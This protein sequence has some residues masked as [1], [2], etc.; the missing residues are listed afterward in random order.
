[1]DIILCFYFYIKAASDL[2]KPQGHSRQNLSGKLVSSD[3][4]HQSHWEFVKGNFYLKINTILYIQPIS[5]KNIF[6]IS[7][8]TQT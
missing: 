1:M 3:V 5:A 6:T 4:S 8:E 7:T 2:Y